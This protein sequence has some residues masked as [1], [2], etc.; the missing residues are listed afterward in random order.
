MAARTQVV[1]ARFSWTH[2][3]IDTGASGQGAKS[4]ETRTLH[5]CRSRGVIGLVS[6][7]GSTTSLTSALASA[8]AF[9]LVS[10]LLAF[11]SRQPTDAL[12][13]T[14]RASKKAS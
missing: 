9:P 10:T 3:A 11:E 14:A 2:W 6:T 12:A 1:Q 5:A 8:G 13:A 4:D 7:P